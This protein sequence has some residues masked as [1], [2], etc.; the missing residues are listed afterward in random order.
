MSISAMQ[1]FWKHMSYLP[2]IGSSLSMMTRKP[3]LS[4]MP[5]G[6]I[7]SRSLRLS[8]PCSSKTLMLTIGGWSAEAPKV[9]HRRR[10]RPCRCSGSLAQNFAHCGSGETR[11]TFDGGGGGAPAAGALGRRGGR[12]RGS[13]GFC[14]RLLREGRARAER[15]AQCKRRGAEA[16]DMRTHQSSFQAVMQ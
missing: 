5:I 10:R 4:S 11:S 1:A 15:Q 14:W 2:S 3:G 6:S 7:R 8:S 9:A 12:R 16:R 13:R